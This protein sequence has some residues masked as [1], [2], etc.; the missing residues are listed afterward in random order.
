[1]TVGKL[2]RSLSQ[3]VAACGHTHGCGCPYGTACCH[4][5]QLTACVFDLPNAE[6]RKLGAASRRLAL[7]AVLETAT[8]AL[9]EAAEVVERTQ[10]RLEVTHRI[11]RRPCA[12]HVEHGLMFIELHDLV[13]IYCGYREPAV[14]DYYQV[15]GLGTEQLMR[16][17]P[18]S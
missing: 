18:T 7:P 6:I 2:Q 1:M 16:E 13:C 4:D 9:E 12:R 15:I 8:R 17:V 14:G 10:H 5:C 11:E 3:R